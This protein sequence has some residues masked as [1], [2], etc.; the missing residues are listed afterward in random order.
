MLLID[1]A[2]V[3]M[4]ESCVHL[5]VRGCQIWTR[6]WSRNGTRPSMCRLELLLPSTLSLFHFV[7]ISYELKRDRNVDFD[8]IVDTILTLTVTRLESITSSSWHGRVCQLVL[9]SGGPGT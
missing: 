3:K 4:A 7:P 6:C 5:Q 2:A 8:S 1:D 9:Q